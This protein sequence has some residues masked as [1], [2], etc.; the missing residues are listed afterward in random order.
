MR[1]ETATTL[2]IAALTFGTLSACGQEPPLP[3]ITPGPAAAPRTGNASPPARQADSGE[4]PAAD[5]SDEK[6]SDTWQVI[7]IGEQRI[8]YARIHSQ[9][10]GE[11]KA[12]RIRTVQESKMTIKRFGQELKL[13]THLTTEENSTGELLSFALEI[14]NPPAATTRTEGKVDGRLMELESNVAGRTTTKSI[15]WDPSVKSPAWQDRLLESRSWKP[16]ATESFRMF[17]P[18]LNKVTSVNIAADDFITTPL[19]DGSKARLQ[20]LRVTQSVL[21]QLPMRVF[22]DEKSRLIKTESDF[23]GKPMLTFNVPAEEALKAIHG[24]E[25]DLAVNTLIRVQP[26]RRA[27]QTE[28]VVYRLVSGSADPA[29]YVVEGPTQSIQRVSEHVAELTVKAIP[30][31]ENPKNERIDSEYLEP[32][33][34]LQSTDAR[35]MEHARRA[36]PNETNPSRIAAALERYVHDKL[37]EKNF[38]TALATAA[39]VARDLEGDCTEHAVLLAAMLRAR[40]IPSRIAVGLVYVPPRSSFGGHM[41]CE[42]WLDGKWIPLDATLGQGGIGAAHIKLG[43]SSFSDDAAAPITAFLPLLRILGDLEIE[44][45]RSE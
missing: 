36:A 8:G 40:K 21:P 14:R 28:K 45:I 31:P 9:S 16:G 38:S 11:G 32:T 37:T 43:Q 19:W 22:L 25:L 23:L 5:K 35:V 7:Y 3:T 41:W 24:K 4:Q 12:A 26:I 30:L 27:H 10:V 39:D 15:P 29:E 20:K 18:E 17:L 42:A 34:F 2:L 1:F 13:E 44:V 33:R 6:D